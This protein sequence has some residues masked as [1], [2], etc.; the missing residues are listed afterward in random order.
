MSEPS[1]GQETRPADI[2]WRMSAALENVPRGG[3]ELAEVANLAD[4]VAEWKALDAGLQALAILTPERPLVI[5]GKA[6]ETLVGE[7]IAE[8]A[9]LL[10]RDFSDPPPEPAA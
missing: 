6:Q 1:W 7:A 2:D 4:V 9:D 5:D 3:S 8:L 10:P